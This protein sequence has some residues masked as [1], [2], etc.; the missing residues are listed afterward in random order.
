MQLPDGLEIRESPIEGLGLF[1]TR[2]IRKGQRLGEYTGTEMPYRDF[3][4]Q[5]GTDFQHTYIKKR[6]YKPWVVRV[7]KGENRNYMTYIND[8]VYGQTV[9]KVNVYLKSWFLYASCDIEPGEELLLEYMK[10]LYKK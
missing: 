7:A 10:R 2:A 3:K 4:S 9:P 5:Y 1:T 8:G 6:P